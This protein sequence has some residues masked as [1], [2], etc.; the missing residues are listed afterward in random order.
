MIMRGGL[1]WY[2]TLA[3]LFEVAPLLFLLLEPSVER[4]LV[5]LLAQ[6]VWG[7][8]DAVDVCHAVFGCCRE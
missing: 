5:T 6:V 3:S 4:L 2:W 8:L 1:L 7:V